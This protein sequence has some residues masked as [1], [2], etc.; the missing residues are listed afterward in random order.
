MLTLCRLAKYVLVL[1]FWLNLLVWVAVFRY[2]FEW[3]RKTANDQLESPEFATSIR[4]RR[5]V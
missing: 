2:A 1:G 5:T 3:L 4:S